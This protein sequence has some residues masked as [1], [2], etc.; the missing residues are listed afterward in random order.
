M[1]TL[2]ASVVITYGARTLTIDFARLA[3][4]MIRDR[5]AA[6]LGNLTAA[7]VEMIGLTE[8]I[9]N[10]RHD[11]DPGLTALRVQQKIV[12]GDVERILAEL[13]QIIGSAQAQGG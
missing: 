3:S 5:A 4:W 1:S 13:E 8:S 6:V 12:A 7:M 10:T 11:A 9:R 2:D